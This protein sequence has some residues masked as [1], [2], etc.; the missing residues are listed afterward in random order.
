MAL[1]PTGTAA[2]FAAILALDGGFIAD[3]FIIVLELIF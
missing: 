2:F 1:L 3:I